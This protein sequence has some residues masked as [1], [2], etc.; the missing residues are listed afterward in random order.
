[1]SLKFKYNE[2][3]SPMENT[4][5]DTH[6]TYTHTYTNARTHTFPVGEVKDMSIVSPAERYDGHK[7]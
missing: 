2:L 4:H 7:N 6:T 1:M 3:F 5:T